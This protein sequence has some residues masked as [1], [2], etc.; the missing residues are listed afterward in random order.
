M[1]K[2]ESFQNGFLQGEKLCDLAREGDGGF[3]QYFAK[4]LT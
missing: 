4:F 2:H 1:E 3:S